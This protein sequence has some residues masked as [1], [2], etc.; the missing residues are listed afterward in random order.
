MSNG[1]KDQPSGLPPDK[2]VALKAPVD[3][4]SAKQVPPDK[5]PGKKPDKY[6][7]K[8]TDELR[9]ILTEQEK[10]MGKLSEKVDQFKGDMDY[11]R[12]KAEATDR[13]RQLYGQNMPQ[14]VVQPAQSQQQGQSQFNWDRPT[15]SV[16][17]RV[18]QRLA[19]RDKVYYQ[20]QVNRVVDEAK[21]A[22]N[23]GFEN[24]KRSN[25]RL[26]EGKEFEREIVDFMYNYYAPFATKGIPV[27]HYLNNPNVWVKAAQSK[28]LDRNEYDRLEPEKI[29]PVS[30]TGTQ[31]PDQAKPQSPEEKPVDLSPGAKQM[32]H[33][34]KD[35]GYVKGEDEAAEMVR[36][37]R[38]EKAELEE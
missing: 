10:A 15:E 11:W 26:F 19:E 29:I 35:K 9:G 38:K 2:D 33:W 4:K 7:G 22:F 24:A 17:Q 31:I 6:E 13:D 27:A 8:S 36:E 16:D 25:P 32:V 5:E 14:T 3:Q 37:E 1:K 30:P 12:T 23:V 21:V 28:R 34:F 18:D 20:D